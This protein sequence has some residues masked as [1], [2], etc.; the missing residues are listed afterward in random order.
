MPEHRDT[1]STCRGS[2]GA[3]LA[4]AGPGIREWAASR[5]VERLAPGSVHVTTPVGGGAIRQSV[6]GAGRR[7][8]G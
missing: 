7:D 5:K 8:S 6:E 2:G 1:G 4:P 3:A